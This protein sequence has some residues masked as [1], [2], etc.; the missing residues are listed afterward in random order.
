M[1]K[2][3][4]SLKNLIGKG[5]SKCLVEKS[6][7]SLAVI[8]TL[9][10]EGYIINYRER[11][12]KVEVYIEEK[13]EIKPISRKGL[14][15]YSNRKEIKREGMEGLIMTVGGISLLSKA[16]KRGIGGIVLCTIE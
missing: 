15:R 1:I 4:V 2:V 16:R 13:V 7:E 8:E 11:K 9:Y 6:K 14:R 12:Y 3:C 10:E 5:Y